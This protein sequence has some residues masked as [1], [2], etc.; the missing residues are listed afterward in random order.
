MTPTA[1]YRT[2]R[3]GSAGQALLSVEAAEAFLG[4]PPASAVGEITVR[5]ATGEVVGERTNAYDDPRRWVWW[6]DADAWLTPDE[7]EGK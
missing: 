4:D 1:Y 6:L 2:R 3:G 5:D 7:L